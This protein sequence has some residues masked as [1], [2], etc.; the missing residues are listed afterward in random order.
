M[1]KLLA[2][3]E[4]LYADSGTGTHWGLLLLVYFYG[5]L[6]FL[7][8]LFDIATNNCDWQYI[9]E[10][11]SLPL[12]SLFYYFVYSPDAIRRKGFY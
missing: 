3:S 8:W 9:L 7:S 12:I 11:N 10:L 1:P 2:I 4:R 5:S 6:L